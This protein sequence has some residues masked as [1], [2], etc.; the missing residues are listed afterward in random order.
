MAKKKAHQLS[1]KLNELENVINNRNLFSQVFEHKPSCKN[2]RLGISDL[3]SEFKQD[4]S[5]LIG[6]FKTTIT[7]ARSLDNKLNEAENKVND[8][9]NV[10]QKYMKIE[11]PVSVVVR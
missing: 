3:I 10:A 9:K 4:F 1:N 6:N 7:S 11:N 2:R 5:G 8:V